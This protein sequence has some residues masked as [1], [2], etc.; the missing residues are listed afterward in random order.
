MTTKDFAAYRLKPCLVL[1]RGYHT[2]CFLTFTAEGAIQCVHAEHFH[3]VG[4][5]YGISQAL[6]YFMPVN[7]AAIR[8]MRRLLELPTDT[9]APNPYWEEEPDSVDSGLTNGVP[10]SISVEA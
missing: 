10:V 5:S 2:L 4:P 9:V 8:Y 6:S 3:P 7:Q 1:H